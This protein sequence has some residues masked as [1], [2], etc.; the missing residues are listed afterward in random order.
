MKKNE[1]SSST[2]KPLV[3]VVMPVF[4]GDRFIDKAIQSILDQT[5]KNFE[6]II[7]NDASTDKSL[8]IINKYKRKDK[9]IKLIN[10]RKNIHMS[11]SINLGISKATSGLI[12]RMDQDD[13]AFS[14]RLEVEYNFM[15]SHPNI[16]IIGSN[17]ITIDEFDR[18]IGKRTYQTKSD[19]LKRTMLRYS[20]FAHPTVMMR[21]KV[22][23]E[24]GGFDP[25][26]VP[27]EDTEFWF[28]VG[29]KYEFASIPR[30][31]L[32]YRV[33]IT[34]LSHKDVRNTEIMGFKIKINAIRK[35]GYKP[36]LYDIIYNIL[37]FSTAWFMPSEMRF[38]LY[39][40]LRSKNLI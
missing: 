4:N 39:D 14:N 15:R 3:S 21:K 5:L 7:I 31:L 35:Y 20:P 29:S 12:A 23:D 22:F 1:Q 37:Q 36:G 16:T 17:I 27:C 26:M 6:F 24:L 8:Q 28:R 25:Q 10:N 9:R 13:I 34:S 32:K 19:S 2:N 18:V 11:R 38:R 30:F 33:V 40:F